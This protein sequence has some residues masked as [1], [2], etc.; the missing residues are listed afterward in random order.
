MKNY[1]SQQANVN[2]EILLREIR[3][4]RHATFDYFYR[5]L[6]Y[7]CEDSINELF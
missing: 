7:Y 4:V 2:A 6:K 5:G 1:K 3:I